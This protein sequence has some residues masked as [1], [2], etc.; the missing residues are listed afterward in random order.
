MCVFRCIKMARLAFAILV[1]GCCTCAVWSIND[2]LQEVFSWSQ[3]DFVFP[4]QETR[5]AAIASGEYIQ[6]NNMPLGLEVWR[7]K[8][9]LTV[10]RWKAG[11]VSTLNYVT[12][13]AG[14]EKN[15]SPLLVPYPNYEMNQLPSRRNSYN[16]IINT[17][18]VDVDECN[19]LWVIDMASANGTSYSEPQLYVIDLIT[20]QVIRQFTVTENLRRMDGTTWFTGLIVDSNPKSC[21]RAY[22]Y[23]AD[24]GWGLLVYSFRDNKAWRMEHPY[25]YFDP[26]A[27]VFN[28]GGVRME[29]LDGVFGLALSE[30]HQ[31]GYRTLY[32]HSLASTRMFS[33]NTRLLQTNSSVSETFDDYQRCGYRLASMQAASM[34]MDLSTGAI[35]YALVNQDAVGCWNPRRYQ[36]HSMNTTAVIAQDPVRLEFP[37][38]IK[39]DSSSNLWVISDR[40]PRFRFRIHDLNLT[41]VNYRVFK[42]PI[43]TAIRGTVCELQEFDDVLFERNLVNESSVP[44]DTFKTR[45]D[46]L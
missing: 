10:P 40:M 39:V 45:S 38:D 36:K 12:L 6:A 46:T 7:D 29:W 21:N 18:R 9:F 37:S 28:I 14:T 22:A 8:L 26:L 16:R 20:D 2:R 30:Q 17:V 44:S 19:R 33:V 31:D 25:F 41:E 1:L 27:T 32:F 15:R 43:K 5:E 11:V 35:F 13:G 23:V 24:I 4:D 3:L 34:A 42:V